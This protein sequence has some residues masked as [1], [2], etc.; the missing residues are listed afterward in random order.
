[1]PAEIANRVTA[2][3]VRHEDI[4]AVLWTGLPSN[5]Q[6]KRERDFT[7]EDAVNFLLELEANRDLA[8]ATYERAREYI[9]NA[10]PLVD[11]AVRRAM[12]T[13]GWDDARL[14][15]ILFEAPP[16]PPNAEPA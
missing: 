13:R 3:L 5:W 15:P 8:E 10:P 9:T 4:Q 6:K 16:S 12:R 1:V 7:P 2:W 14:P 11:T